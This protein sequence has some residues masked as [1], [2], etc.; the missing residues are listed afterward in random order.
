G[1]FKKNYR[2]YGLFACAMT[3]ALI[4]GWYVGSTTGFNEATAAAVQPVRFNDPEYPFISPLVGLVSDPSSFY[5]ELA[6]VKSDV[7]SLIAKEK[8]AGNVQEI[9]LYFR[10]PAGH[11]FGIHPDQTFDPGSLLKLPIM[12]AYLKQAQENPSV[13]SKRYFYGQREKLL[14]NELTPQLRLNSYY[15]AE[16][17]IKSMIIDSDNLAKDILLDSL[18]ETYLTDI[19]QEMDAGFLQSKDQ[20]QVSPREYVRFLSRLYSA[21]FL[22]RYYSNYA[23]TLLS[24]TTYTD[25]LVAGLPSE[26]VVAHKYGERGIYENKRPVGLELHD[27]GIVYV[28]G[29]PYYLCIMTKGDDTAALTNVIKKISAM[30]YADRESFSP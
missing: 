7:E 24:K 4:V 15:S 13:L 8:R 2:T 9:S 27:C 12:I 11:W 17:L 21:T 29:N 6:R 16:E 5:D 30:I 22:N 18:D 1:W 23:L 10:L 28:P 3:I 26:V 19:I 20:I 14:P 25:G